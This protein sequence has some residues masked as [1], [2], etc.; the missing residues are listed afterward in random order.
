MLYLVSNSFEE[1]RN[2][3]ILGMER[4]V[5][6]KNS[7][8]DKAFIDPDISKLFTSGSG[9]ASNLIIA[10][11]APANSK[12]GPDICRSDS[13]G[14]F[15]NDPNTMNSVLFRILGSKPKRLFEARDLQ[16]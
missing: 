5:N 7:K 6:G 10:G 11:A 1:K 12:P 3:P 4:F 13:H 16:F 2:T 8:L 14:G 15:D 9:T